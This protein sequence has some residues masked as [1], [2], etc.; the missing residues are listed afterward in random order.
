MNLLLCIKNDWD[1]KNNLCI[2][3]NC[4]LSVVLEV[5]SVICINFHQ[6]RE[7]LSVKINLSPLYPERFN[8]EKCI[9]YVHKIVINLCHRGM[10]YDDVHFL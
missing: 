8:K 1:A 2:K 7:Q 4:I 9:L 3:C 5:N 6:M 10:C